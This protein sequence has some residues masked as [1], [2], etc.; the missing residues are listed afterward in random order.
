M[1]LFKLFKNLGGN[2]L[3]VISR[4]FIKESRK[5]QKFTHNGKFNVYYSKDFVCSY[6]AYTHIQIRQDRQQR[7]TRYIS[8]LQLSLGRL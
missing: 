7:T 8:G 5:D 4:T 2:V 3:E 6:Y 1:Q